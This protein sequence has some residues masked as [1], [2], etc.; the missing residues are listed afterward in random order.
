MQNENYYEES[1]DATGWSAFLAGACIGA[2]VAL[3]FAPQ[4]GIELRSKLRD[5][6]DRAK[7]ELMEQGRDAWDTAVERGKEYYDN[8]EEVVRDAGQ[9]ERNLPNR[10]QRRAGQ[11]IKEF[12]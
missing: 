2:G 3:L 11:S 12:A 9:S 8:G 5:Y 1:G 6:A 7:D 10:D 4:P